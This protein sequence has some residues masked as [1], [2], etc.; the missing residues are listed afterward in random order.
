MI[1]TEYCHVMSTYNAWMNR[2]L[3]ALCQT[4]S[5]A[6]R[7]AD[8]GA[9]FGSIHAT[10]NHIL[11]GDLAFLSR[12]TGDPKEV[13]ALGVELYSDF[14]E[15]WKAR[16]ATDARI[17][18]W[19]MSLT[20]AWLVENLTYTSLVDGVE[21][22]VPRWAIVVHMLNHQTH[23]R[24]QITALLSQMGLDYGTTDIPFM[25]EFQTES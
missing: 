7:K 3:Y 22:T 4:V 9:F 15:L 24:G 25:P 10:L 1:T 23:H 18:D 16:Q 13:P 20:P 21:R 14:A 5:D 19:S 6:D 17:S 2:R 11:F 12:F 8:R